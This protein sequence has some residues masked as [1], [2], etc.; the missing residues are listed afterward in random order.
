MN[1]RNPNSAIVISRV[2]STLFL[3]KVVTNRLFEVSFLASLPIF[4]FYLKSIRHW[5]DERN[6]AV[7]IFTKL[8]E[9]FTASTEK[10]INIW[11]SVFMIFI[12]MFLVRH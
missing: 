5:K 7:Q 1:L 6:I 3:R 11:L 12:Q 4:L 10:T 8:S 2:L 9:K